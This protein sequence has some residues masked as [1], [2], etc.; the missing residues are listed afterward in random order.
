M[1]H[2]VSC[3]PGEYELGTTTARLESLVTSKRR[4]VVGQAG[5]ASKRTWGTNGFTIG[6]YITL[7]NYITN[8]YYIYISMLCRL[9][10]M[11]PFG[12]NI[13]FG[14]LVTW[15]QPRTIYPN[16][17]NNLYG[18]YDYGCLHSHIKTKIRPWYLKSWWDQRLVGVNMNEQEY[19]RYS[20]SKAIPKMG[21][22]PKHGKFMQ[23]LSEFESSWT[24]KIFIVA[25]I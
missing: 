23:V 24:S 1:T 18:W 19:L 16:K 17:R 11:E 4:L 13:F 6:N 12:H 8:L 2:H 5:E 3:L 25:T 9:V 7:Y 10:T 14:I 21:C 22:D 20:T 15:N